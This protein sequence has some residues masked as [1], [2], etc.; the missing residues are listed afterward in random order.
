MK[1]GE[2]SLDSCGTGRNYNLS[3]IDGFKQGKN[4]MHSK[5]ETALRLLK[6]EK[7]TGVLKKTPLPPMKG[8]L[9]FSRVCTGERPPD[10]LKGT[11]PSQMWDK[12]IKPR[13]WASL[14]CSKREYVLLEGKEPEREESAQ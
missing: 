4:N 5:L 13:D 7:G 11:N 3:T 8:R 1:W 2:R 6:H 9:P 12:G 14:S 10:T